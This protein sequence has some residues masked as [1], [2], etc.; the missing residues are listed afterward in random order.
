MSAYRKKNIPASVKRSVWMRSVGKR[1]E[2]PCLCCY[3][4]IIT[5]FDFQV[6]HIQPERDGGTLSLS[7]LKPICSKCNQS[8]GTQ[9]LH[10]YQ[11]RCKFSMPWYFW[12][13][14]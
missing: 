5:P 9:N 6:G 11:K 1:F 7:N 3:S 2:I 14:Y 8:M 4:H 12:L 10:A 13:V